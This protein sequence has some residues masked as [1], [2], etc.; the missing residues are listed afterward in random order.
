[1][2]LCNYFKR[3]RNRTDI[4]E[5]IITNLQ[6]L[7]PEPEFQTQ[8]DGITE[9][10]IMQPILLEDTSSSPEEKKDEDEDE[11][12]YIEFNV[13]KEFTNNDCIICLSTINLY[14]N[15]IMIKCGHKYHKECILKWFVKNKIC[16]ECDFKL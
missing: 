2:F 12:K 14:E 15:V 16:P 9:E 3:N 13:D 1:M 7:E 8:T 6:A 5:N 4:H 10:E 11:E